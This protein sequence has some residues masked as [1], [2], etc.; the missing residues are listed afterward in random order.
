MLLVLTKVLKGSLWQVILN[1]LIKTFWLSVAISVRFNNNLIWITSHN[2]RFFEVKF[3][4]CFTSFKRAIFSSYTGMKI[5]VEYFLTTF[6]CSVFRITVTVVFVVSNTYSKN[7]GLILPQFFYANFFYTQ[8][9]YTWFWS[10]KENTIQLHCNSSHFLRSYAAL[11]FIE[12]SSSSHCT[13]N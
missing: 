9:I 8:G 2:R 6:F 7:R 10:M 13:V 1:Y 11:D 5:V 12:F 3:N 4:L